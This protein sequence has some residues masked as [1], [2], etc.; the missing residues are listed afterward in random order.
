VRKADGGAY[1][2]CTLG[3]AD[4]EVPANGKTILDWKQAFDKAMQWAELQAQRSAGD[5][6]RSYYQ[7]SGHKLYRAA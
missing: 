3:E 7:A 2:T 6:S 5:R 1:A 4:D